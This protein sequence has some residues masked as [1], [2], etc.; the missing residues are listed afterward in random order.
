LVRDRDDAGHEYV[1]EGMAGSAPEV[2]PARDRTS[3]Q[4]T[5]RGTLEQRATWHNSAECATWH[6]R[7]A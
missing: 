3:R 6:C 2:T 7:R 5:R 4:S 1:L